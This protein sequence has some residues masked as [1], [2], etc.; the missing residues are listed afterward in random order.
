MNVF[1]FIFSDPQ[2]AVGPG[3][4]DKPAPLRVIVKEE[5][6]LS[7]DELEPAQHLDAVK[8]QPDGAINK[9]L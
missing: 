6:K 7:V 5:R 8:L 1:Y 2:K 4:T 3:Q 9:V